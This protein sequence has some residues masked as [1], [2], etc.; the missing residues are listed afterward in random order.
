MKKI[1]STLLAVLL[2]ASVCSTAFA[3]DW[4]E[5]Y[6]ENGFTLTFTDE[7]RNEN[8]KGIFNHRPSGMIDDGLYYASFIYYAMSEEELNMIAEKGEDEISEADR[9]LISSK[10]G[11]LAVVYGI[12]Y[13][14]ISEENLAIQE[15]VA[16]KVT[17]IATAGDVV[18]YRYN[19][20]DWEETK[21]YL[22]GIAP[23]YQ[24]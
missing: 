24:E 20:E 5:V 4:Q 2:L 21:E 15:S 6:E 16:D 13:T 12:D 18:F 19:L 1:L 7:F 17:E 3:D 14:K 23:A 22:A 11:T 9:E 8:L 10:V